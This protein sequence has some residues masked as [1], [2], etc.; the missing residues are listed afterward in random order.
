MRITLL[1]GTRD[2]TD[3]PIV[4]A[5]MGYIL[6]LDNVIDFCKL[7]AQFADRTKALLARLDMLSAVDEDD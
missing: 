1:V 3:R 7:Q 5:C 2:P 6:L 4:L